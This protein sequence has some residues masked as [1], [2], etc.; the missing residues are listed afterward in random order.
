MQA[1]DHSDFK[2][3]SDFDFRISDLFEIKSKIKKKNA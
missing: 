3:V 2:I 1:I